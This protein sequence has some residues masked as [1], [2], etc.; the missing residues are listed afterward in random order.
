MFA[1]KQGRSGIHVVDV[2]NRIDDVESSSRNDGQ[3]HE[4]IAKKQTAALEK[5]RYLP[6]Q[7]LISAHAKFYKMDANI[8]IA[9]MLL[10][11]WQ[12]TRDVGACAR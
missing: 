1:K 10:D 7:E 9:L 2:P 6:G 8:T 11:V 3:S 12:R 4:S 5:G